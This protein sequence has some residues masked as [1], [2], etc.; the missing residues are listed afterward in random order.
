MVNIV[1]H[2]IEIQLKDHIVDNLE[3][4]FIVSI[5]KKKERDKSLLQNAPSSLPSLQ[6]FT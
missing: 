1:E 2:H 3:M 4:K 6:S 5:N